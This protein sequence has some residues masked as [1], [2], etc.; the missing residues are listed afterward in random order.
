MDPEEEE[1]C[2]GAVDRPEINAHKIPA[3]HPK[4]KSLMKNQWPTIPIKFGKPM[5]NYRVIVYDGENKDFGT[6]SHRVAYGVA[7]LMKANYVRLQGRVSTRKRGPYELPGNPLSQTLGITLVLYGKRKHAKKVS[8]IL[9]EKKI[10]L[11]RPLMFDRDVEYVNP[12]EEDNKTKLRVAHNKPLSNPAG[13]V[14]TIEE[15]ESSV[16]KIFDSSQEAK[17]L[18]EME[19]NHKIIKT[20]L[21][22]HQK[23]ALHFMTTR[24]WDED[25]AAE[26]EDQDGN[27]MFRGNSLW[28]IIKEKN[29]FHYYNVV[30][31]FTQQEKPSICRGG[32]LADMMG[33]GKTL[34]VLSLCA[35]T[36]NKAARWA[37]SAPLVEFEDVT[38]KNLKSTLLI[39]PLS[40]V[41]NW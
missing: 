2:F 14:R 40:V 3:P 32:I 19:A 29:G 41:A 6:L 24:E 8:G 30:G 17:E 15:I 28:R 16:M 25:E 36:T 38:L 4:A 33:L 39:A 31:G 10:L 23:Q 21:L 7:P 26:V 35:S 5:N 27:A 11:A 13:L 18:P 37:A 20:P 22:A 9:A 1:V 12:Y 34:S